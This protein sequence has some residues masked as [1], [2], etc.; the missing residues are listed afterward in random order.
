MSDAPTRRDFLH[1]TGG[2]LGV[3]WLAL[4]LPAIRAA[5]T[6]ARVAA[7]EDR[8]LETLTDEEAR[9]LEAEI[10]QSL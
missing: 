7:R 8:P 9:E 3:T 2:S 10:R 6:E 1:H 5:A 4:Q